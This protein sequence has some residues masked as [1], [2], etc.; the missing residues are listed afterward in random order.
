M[1]SPQIMNRKSDS[2]LMAVSVIVKL[3]N[4]ED[5][6]KLQKDIDRSGIWARN[7]DSNPSSA[8]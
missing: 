1:I 4:V 8:T 7:W 2:L 5:T 3:K 6:V